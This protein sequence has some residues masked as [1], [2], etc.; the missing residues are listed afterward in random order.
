MGMLSSLTGGGGLQGGDTS[1]KGG[2]SGVNSGTGA[3]TLNFGGNPNVQS[4]LQ[5]PL[6][7]GAIA[8]VLWLVLRKK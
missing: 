5:N 3:K 6:A 7:L 2:S 1:A 4:A 8:F